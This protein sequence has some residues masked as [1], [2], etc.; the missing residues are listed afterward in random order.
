M[1]FITYLRYISVGVILTPPLIVLGID[2]ATSGRILD[3]FKK[4][5]YAILFEEAPFDQS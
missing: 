4:E 1:R 3:A 5:E 2:P